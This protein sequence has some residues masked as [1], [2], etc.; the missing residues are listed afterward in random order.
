[1]IHKTRKVYPGRFSSKLIRNDGPSILLPSPHFDASNDQAVFEFFDNAT[2]VI[3]DRSTS[4]DSL[5]QI[6]RQIYGA[7][8]AKRDIESC[9]DWQSCI[10][11]CRSQAI[12][13]ALHQDEFTRRAFVKPRGYAG[14]A[15]LLDYIYGSEQF[16]SPPEMNWVGQ[17]LH[18][19]TT[20]CSACQGVKA[21]R[22]VIADLIDTMAADNPQLEFLS[23]AAGHFREAEISSAI[24]RHRFSRAVALD[25]DAESLSR[26]DD[27]Y[28]RFGV[29]TILA[30][31]RELMGGRFECGTF[32]LIYSS[33][34]FD[35]LNGSIS[36]RLVAELFQRLKPGGKLLITNFLEDIE[37]IGYMEA[38]MAWNLLY[39]DR[40]S[41]MELTARIPDRELARA[42]VFCEEIHN[43]IFLL[44][45]RPA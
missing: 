39:R 9:A 42:S 33:G 7:L 45:E 2:T 6:I 13:Q 16:W 12:L 43:V 20:V 1:M 15:V 21:R 23:V 34:L 41:M 38:I 37:A 30:S 4:F 14:D 17:R 22:G 25:S 29:E 35:Y 18:R 19:W 27:D 28:G 24:I 31:A 36:Q 10:G 3:L 32:D 40:V 8:R 5:G 26:I 44:V 11:A